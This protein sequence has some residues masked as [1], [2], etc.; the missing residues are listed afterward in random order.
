MNTQHQDQVTARPDGDALLKELR[1]VISLTS[2]RC[3]A[4]ME[5]IRDLLT[6][7][8]DIRGASLALHGEELTEKMFGGLEGRLA[9]AEAEIGA[10][11]WELTS[12]DLVHRMAAMAKG[13]ASPS[14]E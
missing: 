7:L 8:S 12:R 9:A 14:N 3:E 4:V 1:A 2:N 11:K 5:A 13:G 6:D 10:F